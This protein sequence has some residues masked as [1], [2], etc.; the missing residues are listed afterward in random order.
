MKHYW[1]VLVDNLDGLN[2]L[3]DSLNGLRNHSIIYLSGNFFE[4]EYL[5]RFTSIKEYS[6]GLKKHISDLGENFTGFIDLQGHL[7]DLEGSWNIILRILLP[8]KFFSRICFSLKT[9]EDET[10]FV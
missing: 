9:K 4:D 6:V 7:N 8:G 5:N 10:L 3:V 2:D 1:N